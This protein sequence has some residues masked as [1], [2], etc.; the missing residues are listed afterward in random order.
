MEKLDHLT[1]IHAEILSQLDDLVYE[2]Y[3]H[4]LTQETDY[5]FRLPAEL[6]MYYERLEPLLTEL[7][8]KQV[9]LFS[10]HSNLRE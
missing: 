4:F 9:K 3:S 10:S 2:A 5:E 1:E 8:A 6:C 7:G